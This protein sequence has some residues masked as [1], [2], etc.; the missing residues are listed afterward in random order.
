MT[1]GASRVHIVAPG[2]GSA[3]GMNTML[4]TV[5]RSDLADHYQLRRLTL[6]NDGGRARKLA[7]AVRRF[8]TLGSDLM[9]DQPD[10]VW[11]HATE[12]ASIQRKSI[13]ALMAREAGIPTIVHLHSVV[14]VDHL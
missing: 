9:G 8:S 7:E 12:G 2:E 11:L 3:G 10:L 5:M 6:H 4:N 14:A 13:A 1:E